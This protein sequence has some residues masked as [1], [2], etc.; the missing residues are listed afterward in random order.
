MKKA[1]RKGESKLFHVVKTTLVATMMI[2][3]VFN[4]EAFFV[5]GCWAQMSVE[6]YELMNPIKRAWYVY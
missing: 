4:I 6:I 1:E 3:R 5:G 2:L